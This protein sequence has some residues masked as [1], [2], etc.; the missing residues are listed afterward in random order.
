MMQAFLAQALAVSCLVFV[1]AWAVHWIEAWSDIQR[2]RD[3]LR[4]GD[5]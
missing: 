4:D 3:K 5:N 1:L 2:E